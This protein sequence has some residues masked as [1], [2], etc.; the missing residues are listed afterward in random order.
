MD[1]YLIPLDMGLPV[2][3]GSQSVTLRWVSA[4]QEVAQG[5]V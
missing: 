5:E 2:T 1:I 3:E 4:T